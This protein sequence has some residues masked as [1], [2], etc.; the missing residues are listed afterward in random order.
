MEEFE[1]ARIARL[2]SSLCKSL[3]RIRQQQISITPFKS[4]RNL[5]CIKLM[6]DYFFRSVTHS[7]CCKSI[8]CNTELRSGHYLGNSTIRFPADIHF[9]YRNDYLRCL[10][11]VSVE[12]VTAFEETFGPR[13]WVGHFYPEDWHL[14]SGSQNEIVFVEIQTTGKNRLLRR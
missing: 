14:S 11:I 10:G 1:R 6:K 8:W 9:P 3:R 2:I 13:I 4:N 5:S 12:D 7:C